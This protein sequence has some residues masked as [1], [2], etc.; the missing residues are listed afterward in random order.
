MDIAGDDAMVVIPWENLLVLP[1]TGPEDAP[2]EIELVLPSSATASRSRGAVARSSQLALAR[3]EKWPASPPL[4]A[5]Y[6]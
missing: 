3:Q 1:M 4:S 5:L 6:C 2:L